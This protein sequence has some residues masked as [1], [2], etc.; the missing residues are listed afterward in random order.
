MFFKKQEDSR[1]PSPEMFN[2]TYGVMYM[3]PHNGSPNPY[4]KRHHMGPNPHQMWFHMVPMMDEK[5]HQKEHKS[6]WGC[7]GRK[8]WKHKMDNHEMNPQK[9]PE[10]FQKMQEE[11]SKMNSDGLVSGIP[12]PHRHGFCWRKFSP[13][14][15]N[16]QQRY[17][18][19]EYFFEKQSLHS[20]IY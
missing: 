14:G 18:N 10:M 1:K 3:N 16:E 7:H 9:F 13:G 4:E 8:H 19:P 17:P 11:H 2:G 5:W 15:K 6:H 20:N 12:A